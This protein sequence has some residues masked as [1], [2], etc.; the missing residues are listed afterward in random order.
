MFVTAVQ[1]LVRQRLDCFAHRPQILAVNMHHAL[2]QMVLLSTLKVVLVEQ[3]IALLLP[4]VCFATK[5]EISALP[6]SFQYANS[7]TVQQLI[8]TTVLVERVI[9]KLLPMACFVY[10]YHLKAS[11][12]LIKM[13]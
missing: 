10:M 7:L 8:P 1:Q 6:T 2:L 13:R 3:M 11:A 12:A 9:V 4:M 5:M